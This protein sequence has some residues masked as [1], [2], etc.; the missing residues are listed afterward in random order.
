MND[1]DGDEEDEH[2]YKELISKMKSGDKT[3][4]K[5]VLNFNVLLIKPSVLR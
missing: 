2:L 4:A 1:S 5:K 3:E